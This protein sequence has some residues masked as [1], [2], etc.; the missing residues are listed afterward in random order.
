MGLLQALRSARATAAMRQYEPRN[1]LRSNSASVNRLAALA[2]ASLPAQLPIPAP[3]QRDRVR[4]ASLYLEAVAVHDQLAQ[5][6]SL[7]H[8]GTVRPVR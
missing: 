1:G 3:G 7:R 5:R 6:G 8:V 2:R 4:F